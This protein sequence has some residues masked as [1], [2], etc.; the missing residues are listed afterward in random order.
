MAKALTVFRDTAVE[1]EEKNLRAVA[2]ARQR[3]IDAIE[4]IIGGICTL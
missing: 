3:L 1:I 4:S 2:E